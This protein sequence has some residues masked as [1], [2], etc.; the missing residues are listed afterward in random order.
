M[1]RSEKKRLNLQRRRK[2]FDAFIAKV[3]DPKA[4]RRPGS[5]NK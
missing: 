2:D 1:R 3:D 5:L 4:Y